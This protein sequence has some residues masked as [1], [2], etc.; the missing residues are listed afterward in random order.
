[1]TV[2]VLQTEQEVLQ[3]DAVANNKHLLYVFMYNTLKIL[4]KVGE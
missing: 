3:L 2:N 1:M 4:H